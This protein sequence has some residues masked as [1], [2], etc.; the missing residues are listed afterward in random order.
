VRQHSSMRV[1]NASGNLALHKIGMIASPATG[2]HVLTHLF[3]RRYGKPRV[4]RDNLR[5][6]LRK[7]RVSVLARACVSSMCVCVCVCVCVFGSRT[8]AYVPARACKRASACGCSGL[9]RIDY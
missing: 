5:R 3:D 6:N 1:T 9:Q 4:L 8:R 7:Q 2:D